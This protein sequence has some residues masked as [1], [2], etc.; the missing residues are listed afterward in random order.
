MTLAF[1][2]AQPGVRVDHK[3]RVLIGGHGVARCVDHC[4]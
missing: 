2:R 1:R 3:A 4:A